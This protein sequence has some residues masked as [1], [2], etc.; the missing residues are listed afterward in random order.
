[1]TAELVQSGE[2][3]VTIER[4]TLIFLP[5]FL[6]DIDIPEDIN[7]SIDP[8]AIQLQDAWRLRQIGLN[9]PNGGVK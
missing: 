2:V 4:T 9:L 8:V 6:A 1:M 7:D 5:S 3:K